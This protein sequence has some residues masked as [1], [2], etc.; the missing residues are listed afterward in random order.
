M[1]YLRYD[2]EKYG[3]VGCNAMQFRQRVLS[4]VCSVTTQKIVFF[5]FTVIHT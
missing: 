4:K 3:A 1:L 2:Y 5:R